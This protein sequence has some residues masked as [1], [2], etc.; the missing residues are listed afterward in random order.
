VTESLAPVAAGRTRTVK[1]GRV[2]T[3]GAEPGFADREVRAL[4]SAL[5]GR[6]R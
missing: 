6:A 4:V 1:N 2:R 5:R 3:I